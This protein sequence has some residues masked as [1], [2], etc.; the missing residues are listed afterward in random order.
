MCGTAENGGFSTAWK[1][2]FHAV[3]NPEKRENSGC[4]RL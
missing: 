3:E 1:I 2:F 4:N